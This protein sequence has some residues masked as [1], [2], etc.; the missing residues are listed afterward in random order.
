[1]KITLVL[2]GCLYF[3]APT[4]LA[5]MGMRILAILLII[6]LAIDLPSLVKHMFGRQ[7]VM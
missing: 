4:A 3:F 2:M 5:G 1:M 6:R 7:R